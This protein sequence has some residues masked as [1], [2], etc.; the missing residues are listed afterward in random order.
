MDK[1]KD[2]DKANV[3]DQKSK[4][5][6]MISGIKNQSKDERE[7]IKAKAKADSEAVKANKDEAKGD[8]NDA[9][10]KQRAAQKDSL[11]SMKPKIKKFKP[12]LK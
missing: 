2:D 7:A 10:A 11:S 3:A 12:T 9:L 5:K 1:Q 4:D 8:A 6:E